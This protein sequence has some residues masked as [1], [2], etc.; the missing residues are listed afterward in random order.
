MRTMHLYGLVDPIYPGEMYGNCIGL[1]HVAHVGR[2]RIEGLIKTHCVDVHEAEGR[3]LVRLQRSLLGKFY[4]AVPHRL[5]V[6]SE[7]VS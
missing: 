1:E 5:T 6:I 3:Q 2:L 4:Y 7:R